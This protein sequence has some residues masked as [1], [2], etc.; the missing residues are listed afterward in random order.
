MTKASRDKLL[1]L[2]SRIKQNKLGST[3]DALSKAFDAL[4]KVT[5]LVDDQQDKHN[6]Q[7]GQKDVVIDQ[8]YQVLDQKTQLALD[9]QNK[10]DKLT[11]EWQ[12]RD[13]EFATMK[14][15][16]KG[17]QTIIDNFEARA[18]YAENSICE[19][20]GCELRVPKLG[21]YKPK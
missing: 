10:I 5:N 21:T 8:L 4:E 14:R 18:K 17:M 2:I 19:V 12:E 16:L 20:A 11:R 15:Q 7:M 9:N 13:Y 3:S 1:F 6:K